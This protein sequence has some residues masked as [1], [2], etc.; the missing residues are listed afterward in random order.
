MS[1]N[2]T[3][4]PG[5]NLEFSYTTPDETGLLIRAGKRNLYTL[6]AENSH[7]ADACY[8]HFYNSATLGAVTVGTT[9]PVWSVRLHA[10]STIQLDRGEFPLRHFPL[11]IVIA[12]TL[13]RTGN[14]AP[15]SDPQVTLHF[16]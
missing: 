9:T 3:N 13:G 10:N 5:I 8:L 12:A 7:N 6:I 4:E 16:Q 14:T 1:Y 15:T 11:G 2:K